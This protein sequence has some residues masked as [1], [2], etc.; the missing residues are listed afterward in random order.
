MLLVNTELKKEDKNKATCLIFQFTM[1]KFKK[2]FKE[3]IGY[4]IIIAIVLLVK[5]YIASP[6][7]VSGDSMH[8]TLHDGDV[9]ILDK[10]AYYNDKIKR[11]DIVVI[12][13][14]DRYIIKRVIGLPGDT[15]KYIDNTLYINDKIYLEEFLD[16]DTLTGYIDVE[17]IPEGFYYVLGDNREISLDSRKLGLIE[18]KNIKGKATVT[19]FPFDRLGSKK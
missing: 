19:I 15:V 11:F 10:T 6:I 16:K 9:M 1:E 5:E 7:I 17:E 12:E 2:L 14:N 18:E 3:Y 13:N 4:V 8:S